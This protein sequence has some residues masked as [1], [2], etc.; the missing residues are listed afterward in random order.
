[1]DEY[2][3]LPSAR[4][5]NRLEQLNFGVEWPIEPGPVGD[6]TSRF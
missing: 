6:P 1:M 3:G 5:N 2:E 4:E